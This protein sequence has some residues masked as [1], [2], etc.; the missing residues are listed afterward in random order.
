MNP[1]GVVTVLEKNYVI[2]SY[3]QYVMKDHFQVMKNIYIGIRK[4]IK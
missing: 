2:Q 4:K 3:A 1:S